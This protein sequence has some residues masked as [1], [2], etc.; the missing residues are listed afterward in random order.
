MGLS[1]QLWKETGGMR[2]VPVY[3]CW[4]MTLVGM[5]FDLSIVSSIQASDQWQSFFN[6]PS[7]STLG[8]LNGICTLG[9]VIGAFPA[10]YSSNYLGRK[11]GLALGGV[12]VIIFTL[13]QTFSQNIQ[14][15]LAARF[16]VGFG[17]LFCHNASP[18]ML[19]EF[20]T[21]E[22]RSIALG[23][24]IPFYF[25]G[26]ITMS[27]VCYGTV[28]IQNSWS[29][30]GPCLLQLAPPL[31]QFCMLPFMPE[32]PRWLAHHKK[33]DKALAVLGKYHGKDEHTPLVQQTMDEILDAERNLPPTRWV[34]LVATKGNRIRLAIT[35]FGGFASQMSGNALISFYITTLLKNVGISSS[36]SQTLFNG[37]LNIWL[38]IWSLAAAPVTQ[39]VGRRPVFLFGVTSMLVF[40]VCFVA[41]SAVY[42]EHGGK[43]VSSAVIA[44]IIL[45]DMGY[46]ATWAAVAMYPVELWPTSLRS[47]GAAVNAMFDYGSLF[48]SIYCSPLGMDRYG[49]HFYFLYVA[50]LIVEL[51][52]IYFIFV[53]SN[54]FTVEAICNYFDGE[55]GPPGWFAAPKSK[56]LISEAAA[57]AAA[58]READ[59]PALVKADLALKEAESA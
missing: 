38:F 15:Y 47:K 42:S 33:E 21:T 12:I 9:M 50:C 40:F 27:W 54:G 53:E 1:Y 19:A 57:H 23:I 17:L 5:G 36:K 30:R 10:S 28:N 6:Y 18:A 55:I 44:F 52:F 35:A 49:W 2:R 22:E 7:G 4:A 46:Q 37:I 3:L 43:A 11:G 24:Y 13:I 25:V 31:I 39:K 34:D 45:F 8:L 48:I 29:W 20:S 51:A 59:A 16:F 56:K 58:R 26:S 14:M 41:T 32:S